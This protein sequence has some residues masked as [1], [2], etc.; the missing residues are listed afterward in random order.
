MQTIYFRPMSQKTIGKSIVPSHDLHLL[1]SKTD[2]S[3][4]H[5]GKISQCVA[6]G[7][8]FEPRYVRSFFLGLIVKWRDLR[9]QEGD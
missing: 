8:A 4:R 6:M 1:S 7:I 2:L 5:F 3:Q 9:L